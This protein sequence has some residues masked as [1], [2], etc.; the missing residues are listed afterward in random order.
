MSFRTRLAAISLV[1]LILSASSHAADIPCS[2]RDVEEFNYSWRLRGGLA[3]IAGLRFPT[4]GVGALRTGVPSAEKDAIASEL[5]IRPSKGRSGFYIYQSQIDLAGQKTLM[6]YHGYSWG[7][8]ER[9]ERT[10]FDYVKRLARIRKETTDEAV[11][12]R[13]KPIPHKD[14]RDIL[15]GIYFL[16]RN[17]ATMERPLTSEIYSDG[18]LYPVVFKPGARHSFIVA[19]EKVEARAYDIEAA[20]GETSKKWTG[21]LRV[22]LTDDA[23]HVPVRIEIRKNFASLQLDLQSLNECSAIN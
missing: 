18:K 10:F 16:R 3:W 21:G 23:R 22:W 6:T 7:D 8:R 19:G 17:A 13:V 2:G 5:V 15:T 9:K 14:M 4:S 1:L 20:P 12:N 11:E